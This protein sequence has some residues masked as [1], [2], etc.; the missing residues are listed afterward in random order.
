MTASVSASLVPFYVRN[1]LKFEQRDTQE[2][3]EREQERK[4]RAVILHLHRK[5]S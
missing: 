2:E 5:P 4:Q 1:L 3:E